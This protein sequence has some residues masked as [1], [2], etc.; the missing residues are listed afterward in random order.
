MLEALQQLRWGIHRAFC[1]YQ[2]ASEQRR[3]LAI[4]VGEYSQQLTQALCAAGWSAQQARQANVHESPERQPDPRATT[5]AGRY[6][7]RT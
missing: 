3:A 2:D 6:G 5:A 1:V 7:P 4:E